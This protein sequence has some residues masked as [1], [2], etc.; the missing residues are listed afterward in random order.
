MQCKI[1][2]DEYCIFL[3][4]KKGKLGI[5]ENYEGITLTSMAAKVYS[6]LL[7]NRIKSEIEKILRKNQNRIHTNG[8][9]TSQILTIRGIIEGVSLKEYE[10]NTIVHKY[11][12]GI[13]IHIKREGGANTTYIWSP[14]KKNYYCYNDAL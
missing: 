3:F 13:W 12:R 11:H 6:G 5:S 2:M 10:D 8:S 4:L 14:P 9:T 7:L 1:I